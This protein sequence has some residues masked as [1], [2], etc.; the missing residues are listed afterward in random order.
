M[1]V[2]VMR[3]KYIGWKGIFDKQGRHGIMD[4]GHSESKGV[5]DNMGY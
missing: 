1:H 2:G 5:L 3:H 4:T